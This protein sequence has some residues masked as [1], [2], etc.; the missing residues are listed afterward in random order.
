MGVT[1]PIC[2]A[3][4]SKRELKRSGKLAPAGSEGEARG[5]KAETDDHIPGTDTR[6]WVL[7]VGDVIGDDPGETG[8]EGANHRR[9]KP[10]WGFEWATRLLLLEH[11]LV[12]VA[13][14][15]LLADL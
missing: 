10:T 12:L 2:C 8:D 14:L 11:R 1:R 13:D 3:R 6:D 9:C 4:S 15:D 5:D 7:G